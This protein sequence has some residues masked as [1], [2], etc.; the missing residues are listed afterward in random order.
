MRKKYL[1]PNVPYVEARCRGGKQRPSAIIIRSTRNTSASGAA[2]GRANMMNK[3]NSPDV[4]FHYTVD[5]ENVYR[6]VHDK[7]ASFP[8]GRPMKGAISI[9]LCAQPL[10]SLG[11]WDDQSDAMVLRRLVDLVAHL[12]LAY[13][14]PLKLLD[15]DSENHWRLWRGKLNGGIIL[16]IEGEWPA[17]TFVDDLRAR[18]SVLK[19]K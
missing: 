4:S 2:L 7:V 6:C 5:E 9:N 10:L 3:R 16:Q 17:N 19:Q 8:E 12:V 13:K 11:D 15:E 1:P 14:I 18:V